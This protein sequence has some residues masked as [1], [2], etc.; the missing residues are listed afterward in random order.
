MSS[1]KEFLGIFDTESAVGG[2]RV[3]I[4][5]SSNGNVLGAFNAIGDA[6]KSANRLSLSQA[7]FVGLKTKRVKQT[8]N[9][10]L[11][12]N[13]EIVSCKGIEVLEP[14]RFSI[15]ER[16][17]FFE[18]IVDL[19]INKSAL[20]AIICGP[21]G[22]GKTYNVFRMLKESGKK[23]DIDYITIKGNISPLGLFRILQI[24]ADKIIVMDDCDSC[25]FNP[26]CVN[27]LKSALDNHDKR[28]ITWASFIV[29][30]MEDLNEQ[31]EF[32]GKM[33][34]VSNMSQSSIDPAI[35]S[36]SFCLDLKMTKADI[37]E[38]IENLSPSICSK[39]TKEDRDKALGFIE[40]NINNVK[41]LNLRTL[42]KLEKLINSGNNWEKL[43][44]YILC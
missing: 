7:Q 18:K 40:N 34:F 25:L 28:V 23:E 8:W 22:I 30:K 38:H 29:S 14:S 16:F 26:S 43:A 39:M 9:Q 35:I 32:L 15:E 44:E 37:L 1:V 24:N 31:F 41:E 17:Q 3:E 10:F 36:R 6:W 27:L 11:A 13:K 21:P 33:L 2:N 12:E 4:R 20:A 42:Q 19:V 5:L